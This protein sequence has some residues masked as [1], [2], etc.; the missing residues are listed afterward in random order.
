[1]KHPPV[2]EIVEIISKSNRTEDP[3]K[4]RWFYEYSDCE[5]SHLDSLDSGVERLIVACL[6]RCAWLDEAKRLDDYYHFSGGLP[7][8]TLAVKRF[9]E[10]KAAT[11]NADAWAEWAGALG[12]RLRLQG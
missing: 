4:Q 2:L 12:E 9:E 3:S 7:F 8:S 6:Q 1:M 11:T 10:W 5:D